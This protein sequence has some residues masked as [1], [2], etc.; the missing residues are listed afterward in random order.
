MRLSRLALL[1]ALAGLGARPALAAVTIDPDEVMAGS[2]RVYQLAGQTCGDGSEYVYAVSRTSNAQKRNGRWRKVLVE[3]M[4]GGGCFDRT[5]C[6]NEVPS[7]GYISGVAGALTGALNVSLAQLAV[8]TQLGLLRAEY[9][10]CMLNA[11]YMMPCSAP[12]LEDYV[13]VA[14]SYCTG[15]V[16]SGVR[17]HTYSEAG[18]PDITVQHKG[19]TISEEILDGLV[20]SL[21]A[22]L[23]EVVVTG[24]SA[25]GHGAIVWAG[26]LLEKLL[27]VSS[28]PSAL[29]VRVLADSSMHTPPGSNLEDAVMDSV[30]PIWGV[31]NA[32]LTWRGYQFTG[33][34]LEDQ[35]P[36][37]LRH[38]NGQLRIAVLACD[39]DAGAKSYT[40]Y[41][42]DRFGASHGVT[43]ANYDVTKELYD[44]L[45]AM[46]THPEI[47]ANTFFSYVI[48]G[49]C[50][51]VTRNRSY[52]DTAMEQDWRIRIKDDAPNLA[53]WIHTFM[54]TGFP[55]AVGDGSSS[56]TP[57]AVTL[58][59]T[60]YPLTTQAEL[61]AVKASPHGDKWWCCVSDWTNPSTTF[62][63]DTG[64]VDPA[65]GTEYPLATQAERERASGATAAHG[66]AS[67]AATV[68]LALSLVALIL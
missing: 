25:G 58:A 38:Y 56:A 30:G 44:F 14:I 33:K 68:S 21:G 48:S 6:A 45:Q 13:G 24:G 50:H 22:D 29:Q 61:D 47:P 46:H 16:H 60:E 19:A 26:I 9:D 49:V 8:L 55:Y 27:A 3:F 54:T 42:V 11:G 64:F 23:E 63:K 37:Q 31:P 59:G 5:T 66:L 18:R 20:S 62:T 67:G 7:V 10:D 15:D 43:S 1:A 28:N 12:E 35:I 41:L 36:A 39:Q 53:A 2:S 52:T 40:D 57:A 4:G 51:H 65:T 17:A 34:D 32:P